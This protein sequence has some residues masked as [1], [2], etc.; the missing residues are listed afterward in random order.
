MAEWKLASAG[1][2]AAVLTLFIIIWMALTFTNSLCDGL[3]GFGLCWNKC[4]SGVQCNCPDV[5]VAPSP[6]APSPCVRSPTTSCY[7]P[8]PF[9]K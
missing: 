7:E 1:G 6:K 4:Q 5:P 9:F 8:E 3:V 2:L